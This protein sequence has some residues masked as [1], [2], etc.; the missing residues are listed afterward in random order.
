MT[1]RHVGDT[2]S[3]DVLRGGQEMTLQVGR[4]ARVKISSVRPSPPSKQTDMCAHFHGC[5]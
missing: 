5:R 3:L 1:G 4:G 2:L